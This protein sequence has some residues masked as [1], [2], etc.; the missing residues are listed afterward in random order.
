MSNTNN[1][2][3]YI[4]PPP[5]PIHPGRAV[6]FRSDWQ[7]L[8]AP[9]APQAQAYEWREYKASQINDVSHSPFDTYAV[10][11]YPGTQSTRRTVMGK[12]ASV[13]ALTPIAPHNPSMGQPRLNAYTDEYQSVG[14]LGLV[15]TD[16]ESG[17]KKPV[18][19]WRDLRDYYLSVRNLA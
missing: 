1:G 6:V 16:P 2:V 14:T 3:V 9:P 19:N 7:H 17:Q 15:W 12:P 10:R 8:P 5:R 4:A 11:P 18:E 13:E